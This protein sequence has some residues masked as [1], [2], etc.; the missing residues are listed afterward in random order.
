MQ[1]AKH[2][3]TDSTLAT[4]ETLASTTTTIAGGTS[5]PL[6]T[7]V[8]QKLW[9]SPTRRSPRLSVAPPLWPHRQ[10]LSPTHSRRWSELPLVKGALLRVVPLVRT[11]WIRRRTPSSTNR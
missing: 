9:Y 5:V 7:A 10:R 6:E 8:Q 3:E 1:L 11:C 4:T 2:L